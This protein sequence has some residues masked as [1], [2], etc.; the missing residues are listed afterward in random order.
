[1]KEA[2]LVQGMVWGDEGKG[3]TVD[4]LTREQGATLVV[5]YNGGGQA[6]H[7]VVTADGRHHT[8]SQF[9]AGSFVPGVR[10]H[11][12]K[13]FLISP[14]VQRTEADRLIQLGLSDIWERTTIHKDCVVVT[15]FH[16]AKNRLAEI[17]RG[18]GRHGSCGV[19]IGAAREMELNFPEIT[20][21]AG[22]LRD[23][24]LV[25][26]ILGKQREH[27]LAELPV[28][29]F[30]EMGILTEID[31]PSLVESYYFW[32]GQVV[33]EFEPDNVMIFEGAQGVLLDEKHGEA[34]YYTWTNCTFENALSL[35][36]EAKFE[37]NITKVGCFRTYF[38]RHGAGPFPTQFYSE[39]L[40]S[41]ELHNKKN[42]WQGEWRIGSFDEELAKK[43]ISIVG[44][45]DEISLSHN[46]LEPAPFFFKY[47]LGV[48]VTIM[49]YGPT[50]DDR[51]RVGS[52]GWTY[53]RTVPITRESMRL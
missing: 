35:L 50:A 18:E 26:Y 10:T 4:Y 11:L 25:G 37:G 3:A 39:H 49:G 9:G 38:T 12:S 41:A 2:I 45:L 13:F 51:H 47:R 40:Q 17:L 43:A 34:P 5:R 20:L 28:S 27:Y 16:R 31:I 1:M 7:N 33:S 22:D 23:R 44:G 21:R 29:A 36:K 42:A 46:D 24:D 15:P 48:P 19:G 14:N 8:F 32:P 53:R 52:G 30:I 6:A